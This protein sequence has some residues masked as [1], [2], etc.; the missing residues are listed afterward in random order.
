MFVIHNLIY[1]LFNYIISIVGLYVIVKGVKNFMTNYNQLNSSQRE[2]IQIL[3]NKGK[4]FTEI[5][6]AI[7][8]DRTTISK[9]IRR[10]R[11]IK[12]NFY[13]AFDIK[14][15]NQAIDTCD[16][17]KRKPYVCNT[18]PNKK[19]CNKHHIYYEYKLAEEH[20]QDNLINSRSG[21]DIK[22]ETID[23]IESQIVP[24]IKNKKQSVNQVYINHSDILYFSKSTFYKYVDIGVFSLT[25]A[26]L[27]KKIR[28]KE[29]NHKNT[30][31][32]NKREL[33]LLKGR[34]YED[35][36]E[37]SSNHPKMN[38]VEMDTVIGKRNDSKCLLTLYI[39]KT[40]FM[41][42][43]LLNKKDS[44]SVNA[45]INFIKE[46]IGIKLYSKVFRIFLTDNG[47]E[48]FSVLNFERDSITDK[49]V[50]NIFFCHPYSSYEK[51]GVEVNHE[52]IRRVF[53][54]NSSFTNLTDAIVK[55]LQD[56]INSIPR[57]S[58]GNETPY[59]LTK[60]LYSDL[61]EKLDCKYI[62]PDD[63]SLS[64]NDILL[65]NEK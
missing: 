6:E 17:L 40:H 23:D 38:I 21:I 43:F 20:Y 48:F 39:R 22:P 31:N 30:T 56:N 18:C 41:L 54:K 46:T 10:N 63:V 57:I 53:P 52:Y 44:A 33:S 19:F 49:K 28:Y 65:I 11:Y 5:G 35:F 15:I 64:K 12:S 50:S 47:S 60:Q 2:T 16:R 34:K 55:N 7:C 9:E 61:I 45:K 4:S 13:D 3:L 8:K 59:N 24:L 27:P 25:N 26:D 32:K 14:G 1:S 51:H 36:T 62:K 29:R 58:L 42:I 37:F